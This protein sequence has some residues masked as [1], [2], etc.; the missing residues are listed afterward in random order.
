MI[1]GEISP[2]KIKIILS[3]IISLHGSMTAH[4][5]RFIHSNRH[6]NRVQSVT[7]APELSAWSLSSHR[8]QQFSQL[9]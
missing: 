6:I 5:F 2:K 9:L 4:D 3:F 8:I 7:A 1:R